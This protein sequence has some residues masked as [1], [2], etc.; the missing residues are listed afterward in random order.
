ML[1]INI[2]TIHSIKCL[3]Y[4]YRQQ[5]KKLLKNSLKLLLEPFL[6]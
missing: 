6:F 4:T 3:L 2:N 1:L 5:E